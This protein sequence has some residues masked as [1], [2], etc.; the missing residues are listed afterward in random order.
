MT[1]S[2]IDDSRI[3]EFTLAVLEGSGWYTVNYNMTEPLFWGKNEGCGFMTTPC[4]NP[5]TK[6]ANFVE[7]CSTI[8]S[9]GCSFTGRS[10]A[11]CGA[12][13]TA[14]INT[15]DNSTLTFGRSPVTDTF[16]D[17]CPY[18]TAY[19]NRDCKNTAFQSDRRIVEE[20]YGDNSQL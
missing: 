18:M 7:F 15:V 4:L 12:D 6:Q 14:N 16:A 8:A 1:A 11:Y 17:N 19:E 3:S 10:Q 13:T 2:D 9:K 5:T 20:T